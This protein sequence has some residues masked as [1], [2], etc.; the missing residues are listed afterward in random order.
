MLPAIYYFQ[1]PASDMLMVHLR[2]WML[3][4]V[5]EE[6]SSMKQLEIRKKRKAMMEFVW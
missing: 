3:V 1:L 5:L 4:S 2:K 6:D